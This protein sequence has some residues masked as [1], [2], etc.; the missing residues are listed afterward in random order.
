[1]KSGVYCARLTQGDFVEYITFFVAAP[2]GK[3]SSR[4]AFWASD[5]NYLAYVGVSLGVTARKNYDNDIAKITNNV[6]KRFTDP[7]P[8]VSIDPDQVKDVTRI[9]PNPE[10]EHMDQQ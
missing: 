6:L 8:F 3:P 4:L 7:K 2:K 9:P 5:Y 1:M 10:Y